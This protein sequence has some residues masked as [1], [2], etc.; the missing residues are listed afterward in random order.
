MNKGISVGLLCL[1]AMGT[2]ACKSEG[3][4]P[5]APAA[6]AAPATPPPAA[7][8]GNTCADAL[9]LDISS[10]SATASGDLAG[11]TSALSDRVEVTGYSWTGHD[12]FYRVEATA[13]DTLTIT[14]A[15][16]GFDGGIYVFSDCA[17]AIA[18][19]VGGA[20]TTSTRP[21]VVTIPTTGTYFIAVDSWQNATTG[22]FSLTVNR[23]AAAAVPAGAPT[24]ASLFSNCPTNVQ[25]EVLW[26]GTWYA[27][28]FKQGPNPQGQCQIGYD[29]WSASWDEWVGQDRVRIPAGAVA[30]A[31]PP[32][33]PPPGGA[34]GPAD[35]CAAITGD[36]TVPYT[37]PGDLAG[38]TNAI[39]DRIEVTGYSWTGHD[40]FYRLQG[41]AG[42]TLTITLNDGGTFDGGIYVFTDCNNPVGS[43]VGG[44]DTTA[45]RPAVVTLPAAGTYFVAVDSWANA[46]SGTYTLSI[47]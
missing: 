16:Q 36:I 26:N 18:T 40:Q 27:S 19:V 41:Q 45:S 43:V 34:A 12:M 38:K 47:N 8:T 5:A 7:P 29:G 39:G 13:G 15:D 11:K 30:A 4:T 17:N 42:Q 3:E 33:T 46:T 21:A 28:H 22:T 37:G 31:A 35:T 32:T 25:I 9:A 1:I 23:A 6:P 14:L 2:T 24:V 44:A 10:G 20:D